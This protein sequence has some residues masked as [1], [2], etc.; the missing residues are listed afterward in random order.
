MLEITSIKNGFVLDHIRAGVGVKIFKYLKLEDG[1]S[2][3]ALIINANSMKNG[4]KDIIKI[5]NA[6]EIDFTV[7]ALLSP[8]ITINEIK[9]EVRVRKI[10]P[11]L[12]KQVKGIINCDNPRCITNDEK[13]LEHVFDLVNEDNGSYKCQYCDTIINLSEV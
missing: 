4:R 7:L 1:E 8:G 3:V 10:K 5:E 6:T 12:P 2:E 11:S 13:Y 9:N